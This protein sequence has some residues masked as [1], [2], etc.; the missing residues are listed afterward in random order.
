MPGKVRFYDSAE[1]TC[2]A[3]ECINIYGAT[4]L[5]KRLQL[6]LSL[7]SVAVIPMYPQA[8][9]KQE[10]FSSPRNKCV[11]PVE[12]ATILSSLACSVVF[13]REDV[14]SIYSLIAQARHFMNNCSRNSLQFWL[15]CQISLTVLGLMGLLF[16]LPPLFVMSDVIWLSCFVIPLLALTLSFATMGR[17]ASIMHKSIYKSILSCNHNSRFNKLFLNF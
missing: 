9:R 2:Y 14:T 11:S 1:M 7:Y 4:D 16:L 3:D 6:S 8:C 17:V 10:C 12:V 15:S 5:L 13:K